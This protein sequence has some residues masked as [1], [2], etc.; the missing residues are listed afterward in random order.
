MV[1]ARTQ[2]EQHLTNLCQDVL[3]LGGMAETAIRRA[4]ESIRRNDLSARPA[5]C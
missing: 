2:F 4:M 1:S 3:D 5:G